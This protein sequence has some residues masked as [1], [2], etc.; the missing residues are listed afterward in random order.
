MRKKTVQTGLK[1]MLAGI[2]CVIVATFFP[3]ELA[4]LLLLGIGGDLRVTFLGFF[5]GGVCGGFGVLVSAAGLLQAGGDEQGVRL[6]PTVMLLLSLV[7]IFF[8]LAYNAFTT[9]PQIPQLPRGESIN[10]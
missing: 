7:V 8:V 9:I 4:S 3:G 6:A 1:F 2:I 10:I 5:L